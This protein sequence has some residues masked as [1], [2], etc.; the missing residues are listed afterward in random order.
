MWFF[1]AF[2][3]D[4]S[5]DHR[6][7]QRRFDLVLVAM[8]LNVALAVSVQWLSSWTAR[9]S[10]TMLYAVI[11]QAKT[12]ATVGMSIFVFG[13]S[14]SRDIC[15]GLCICLLAAVSLSVVEAFEDEVRNKFASRVIAVSSIASLLLIVASLT[16]R[17]SGSRPNTT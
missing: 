11:G 6:L 13:E 10:S 5:V 7:E 4:E 2:A 12:A 1:I 8:L 9:N 14:L 3:F 16:Q 17:W 15:M